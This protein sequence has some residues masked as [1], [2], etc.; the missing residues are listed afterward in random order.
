MKN[1]TFIKDCHIISI[2][3]VWTA[4]LQLYFA[5]YLSVAVLTLKGRSG[6]VLFNSF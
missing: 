6:L 5:D 2:F 3:S 1:S 4:S